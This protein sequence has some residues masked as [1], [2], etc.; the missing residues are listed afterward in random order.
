[1]N[2]LKVISIICSILAVYNIACKYRESKPTVEIIQRDTSITK[3]NAF[4]DLHLD[5]LEVASFLAKSG[6]ADSIK[7]QILNFYNARNYQYAWFTEEGMSEQAQ[8]FWNINNEYLHLTKDSNLYSDAL[9]KTMDSLFDNGDHKKE[10]YKAM[11]EIELKTTLH[12][13]HFAKPT[14]TGK[15]N[16][17]VLQ[18]HIPRKKIDVVSLLDSLLKTKGED[19]SSWEPVNKQYQALKKQLIRL[20]KIQ[21]VAIW[22]PIFLENKQSLRQGDSSAIVNAIRQR[23]LL[24]GDYDTPINSDVYDE[25]MVRAVIS[26]QKRFGVIADGV[27]GP[28]VIRI[29][30]TSPEERIQQVLVNMERFRWLP[31]QADG[32]KII[33]NIPEF[34]LRVYEDNEQVLDMNVVVGKTATRTVI[35]SDNLKFVVLSPYWNVPASIVKNEILPGMER[36]ADYLSA[37]NMEVTGESNGFPVIRQKP[38]A[39]NSLG[40]VKFM[41]PNKYNIYLHDT[42]AKRLFRE[43]R[44]AFSHGCIRVSK[45]FELAA[46][47]LKDNSGWSKDEIRQAMNGSIEKWVTLPTPVPVLITYF[48]A[49]VDEEGRLN[50]RRDIYGHDER[51]KKH[52]FFEGTEKLVSR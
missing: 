32:K 1:M 49:W 52:L 40:K 45:P 26:M 3:N 8:L 43:N 41:F 16:P 22:E 20:N 13:F 7:Q 36:R 44:R 29:L 38:G 28:Q 47:L 46:Y 27:I 24:T 4:T 9:Y 23:L 33:V 2:K 51:M 5:S 6:L 48:T 39:G 42:P 10:H 17:K 19:L 37:Y 18:W 34:K 35:F 15:I 11:S 12:F 30:N 14:Y 31:D 25:N 50:F 21:K